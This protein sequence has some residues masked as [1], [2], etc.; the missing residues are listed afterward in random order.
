M[1]PR[2]R[3]SIFEELDPAAFPTEINPDVHVSAFDNA[4]ALTERAV[5][6]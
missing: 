3:P 6:T 4:V 5:A 2:S 1:L